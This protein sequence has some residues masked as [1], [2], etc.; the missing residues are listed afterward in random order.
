[1]HF[2][3]VHVFMFTAKFSYG[4]IVH[5]AQKCLILQSFAQNLHLTIQNGSH[6]THCRESRYILNGYCAQTAA[7]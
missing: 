2:P 4:I 7:S 5:Y 1:M 6:A 3:S